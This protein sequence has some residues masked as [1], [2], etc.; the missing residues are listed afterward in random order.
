MK[1]VSRHDASHIVD[2]G[3]GI[4]DAI[5]PED[6]T[7]RRMSDDDIPMVMEIEETSFSR[8]WHPDTFRSLAKRPDTEAWVGVTGEGEVAGYTV[9]WCIKDQAELANIAVAGAFQNRGIGSALLSKVVEVAR[10]RGVVSLFLE[11]RMSNEVAHRL[12]LNRG[13]Q[14]V[15]IRRGYYQAPAEDARVLAMRLDA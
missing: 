5:L 7:L 4:P 11:V 15:G 8:P 12:Y 6:L 13:F 3:D 9:F 1:R 2:G 14:Q 10:S